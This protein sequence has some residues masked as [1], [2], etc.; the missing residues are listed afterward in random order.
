MMRPGHGGKHRLAVNGHLGVLDDDVRPS[1]S[2][3]TTRRPSGSSM[4]ARTLTPSGSSCSSRTLAPEAAPTGIAFH[5]TWRYPTPADHR[6][7]PSS[8]QLRT[9]RSAPSPLRA[10][11]ASRRPR[12]RP[13][14]G[15]YW[16][17]PGAV[18]PFGRARP[19]PRLGWL[20]EPRSRFQ[21]AAEALA[22]GI[23]HRGVALCCVLAGAWSSSA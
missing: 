14:S 4:S 3:Q 7:R 16:S 13:R 8:S 19:W 1:S 15:R 2:V 6:P 18:A 22:T 21:Q 9:A 17:A 23:T 5:A 12:R 11:R 20:A 10:R